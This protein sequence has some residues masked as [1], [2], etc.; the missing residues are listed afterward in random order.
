MKV[1]WKEQYQKECWELKTPKNVPIARFMSENVVPDVMEYNS[2]PIGGKITL[3]REREGVLSPL[4]VIIY[5]CCYGYR[6]KEDM[7]RHKYKL[8]SRY[9][10][11]LLTNT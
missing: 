7:I 8:G 2:E 6:T 3:L 10:E 11:I 4:E 1:K 5:W 9:F